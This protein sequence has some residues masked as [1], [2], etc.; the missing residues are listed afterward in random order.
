MLLFLPLFAPFT[1]LTFPAAFLFCGI[2]QSLVLLALFFCAL[3][4]PFEVKEGALT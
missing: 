2:V 1:V 3:E 4:F